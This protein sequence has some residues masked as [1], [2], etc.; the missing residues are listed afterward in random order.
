MTYL[1]RRLI[2]EDGLSL[3]FRDYGDAASVATPVLCLAG[4][5]R[6]SRDFDS[7]ACRLA[8]KRRVLCPDLRG[9]GCSDFDSNWN[10]YQPATY[11][12]DITQL[13]SRADIHQVVVVGTSFGGLL[14]LALGTFMPLKIAGLVLN[15]VGPEI[16]PGKFN[17][18]LDY[19]AVDHPQPDWESA[20][21]E[22]RKQIPGALFQTEALFRTMVYNTYREGDD[23]LLHF[24]WDV[25][26]AKP[27]MG[28]PN[29]NPNL[30]HCL[31][32]LHPIPLLTFRGEVSDVFSEEC[33]LRIGQEYPG[34]H[35]VTVPETGHAPTLS[36]PECIAA[37]DAFLQDL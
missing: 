18:V 11:L 20:A 32:R 4:L 12:S 6:N 8:S 24:D 15:D 37:L 25:N 21:K 2:T 36:E 1:E 33:F 10:N 9:R 22:I 16:E 14:A 7:I 17:E 26:I 28:A 19:I 27:L 23:G 5:F 3:Y 13:L 31:L 34:T 30:W 35:L 29:V